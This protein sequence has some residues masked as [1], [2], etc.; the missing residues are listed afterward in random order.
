MINKDNYKK[1]WYEC[2]DKEGK[3]FLCWPNAGKLI[4]V[5]PQVDTFFDFDHFASITESDRHPIQE[6]VKDL[7]DKNNS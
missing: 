5:I 2:I 3:V 4:S 6:I 7:K 1:R